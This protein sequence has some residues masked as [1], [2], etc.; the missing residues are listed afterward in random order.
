MSKRIIAILICLLLMSVPAFAE[1]DA[2]F[3]GSVKN[4][5]N[6]EITVTAAGGMGVRAFV[7]TYTIS[8]AGHCL[9][10]EVDMTEISSGK[11]ETL[12]I[13]PPEKG[14]KKKLTVV[15]RF[16][17]KPLCKSYEYPYMVNVYAEPLGY[18]LTDVGTETYGGKTYASNTFDITEFMQ[19]DGT[20]EASVF[21]L[22]LA[23]EK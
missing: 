13:T 6:I 3:D 10:H 11:S 22:M 7:Y 16:T 21:S 2:S 5:E 20:E 8:G 23:S 18:K 19:G 17:L 9:L 1:D 4:G 12:V 14:Y 15:D